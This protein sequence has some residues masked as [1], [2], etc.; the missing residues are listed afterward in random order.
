MQS[1]D[2]NDPIDS[3]DRP[4]EATYSQPFEPSYSQP[5]ESSYIQPDYR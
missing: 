3:Y 5:F 1:P 2:Y 4:Y